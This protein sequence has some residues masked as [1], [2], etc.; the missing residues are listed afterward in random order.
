MTKER[1]LV[2]EK[3]RFQETDANTHSTWIWSKGDSEEVIYFLL[4][5]HLL[6]WMTYI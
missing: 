2:M 5:F 6:N 3:D 4:V 1:T